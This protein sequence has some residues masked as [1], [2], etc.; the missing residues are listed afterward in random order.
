MIS[1]KKAIVLTICIAILAFTI[2]APNIKDSAKDLDGVYT[3]N[4]IITQEGEIKNFTD[5]GEL[6]VNN[7]KTTFETS[8]QSFQ[9]KIEKNNYEISKDGFIET[10]PETNQKY[11]WM[12][13]NK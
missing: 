12:N 3:L 2:G 9:W 8:T 1:L 6:T 11:V 10:D 13:I 5:G 4:Q 7:L